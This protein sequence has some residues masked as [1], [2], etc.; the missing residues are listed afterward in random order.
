MS[1]SR[2]MAPF[3]FADH[4]L[5]EL[6]DRAQVGVGGEVDLDQRPLGL[7]HGGEEVV[8]GQ[9]LAHLGRADVEGRHPVRLEPDA[10][11]EGAGAENIGPLHPFDGREPRL[12]DADQVVGDL[13]LLEDVGGEAQIG[14]GELAVG[15]FDVDDRHLGLRRQIAADLVDLG[16]DLGQGLGGVVVE[17]QAGGDGREALGA[18]GFDVIDAV[19]GGDGP[20]QGRGDEAAHQ[21]GAGADIDGGD[22]D[23][24]RSRCAG[25]WRTFR[26]RIACRP[27]MMIT[28][29]TTRA[30]TGRRMKRSVNFMA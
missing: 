11:G 12:N 5:L 21:F 8:G 7:A 30:R 6:L 29:L 17:L 22:R 26:V 27:A 16:A 18:L 20:L 13:V 1:S 9:R 28:R 19:G 3:C 4:Q 25:Y 10:H 23:R 15:R 14:R 2:T 24:R